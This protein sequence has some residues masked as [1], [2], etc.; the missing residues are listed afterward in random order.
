MAL[1]S[2]CDFGKYEALFAFLSNSAAMAASS[3]VDGS[4]G[5]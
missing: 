4:F 1:C 5:T 2:S 3:Q